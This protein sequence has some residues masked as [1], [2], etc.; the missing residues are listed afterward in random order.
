MTVENGIQ[1]TDSILDCRYRNLDN[2]EDSDAKVFLLTFIES[3]IHL[4]PAPR[5]M[6][7]VTQQ[8]AIYL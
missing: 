2:V 8:S 1:H 7:E 4:L 3:N 6:V 5:S